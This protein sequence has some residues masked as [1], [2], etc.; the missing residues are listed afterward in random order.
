MF[1]QHGS[2]KQVTDCRCER[3]LQEGSQKCSYASSQILRKSKAP[4]RRG[5][6]E[7]VSR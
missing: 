6:K 7:R 1:E 4:K 2:Q 5:T 3:E